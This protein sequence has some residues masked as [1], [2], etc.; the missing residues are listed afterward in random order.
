MKLYRLEQYNNFVSGVR[1]QIVNQMSYLMDLYALT[2]ARGAICVSCGVL[3]NAVHLVTEGK[4]KGLCLIHIAE[5]TRLR[6]TSY[7]VFCL[8]KRT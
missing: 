6:P 8:K 3:N 7:A 4:A 5:P 2:I 1:A